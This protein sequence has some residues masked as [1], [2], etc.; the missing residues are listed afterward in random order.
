MTTRYG[1]NCSLR[2]S[3]A[4][5]PELFHAMWAVSRMR[6]ACVTA[7]WG[8]SDVNLESAC[9]AVPMYRREEHR[10]GFVDTSNACCRRW[11]NTALAITVI[12][13]KFLEMEHLRPL[14]SLL[15]LDG[16]TSTTYCHAPCFGPHA[17]TSFQVSRKYDGV[18]GTCEWRIACS[19]LWSKMR[20][21]SVS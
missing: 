13:G 7:S 5:D 12:T 19:K 6:S 1:K 2:K 20:W 14:G 17:P 11:L 3:N 10:Y 18:L 16:P 8:C 4:A 9:A 21:Y 15:Y